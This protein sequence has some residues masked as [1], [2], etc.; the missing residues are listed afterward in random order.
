VDSERVPEGILWSVV[1]GLG[2]LEHLVPDL[3][4]ACLAG[5]LLAVCIHFGLGE[6]E[7]GTV[8]RM[9]DSG[10]SVCHVFESG[11]TVWGALIIW[12]PVVNRSWWTLS[13]LQV[14]VGDSTVAASGGQATDDAISKY[15]SILA[16]AGVDV[17]FDPAE[18]LNYLS[19]CA[20]VSLLPALSIS[21]S[22]D[23]AALT[24]PGS[25]YVVELRQLCYLVHIGADADWVVGAPFLR[26]Y[27]A[28]YD[29]EVGRVGLALS[30][31]VGGIPVVD[32]FENGVFSVFLASSYTFQ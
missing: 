14:S 29:F 19:A 2:N 3:Q 18:E 30:T 10:E 6:F 8:F 23:T 12:I 7:L 4:G 13:L 5:R 31:G 27:Y 20:Q 1:H 15:L 9:R 22:A 16:N 24:L 17:R 11:R 21:L 32:S 26:R 25:A 28:I